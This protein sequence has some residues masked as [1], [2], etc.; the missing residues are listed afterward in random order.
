MLGRAALVLTSRCE[1]PRLEAV[2]VW[3]QGRGSWK[4]VRDR[5]WEGPCKEVT[6]RQPRCWGDDSRVS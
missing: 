2:K 6:A 3:V 5:H 4:E 1:M